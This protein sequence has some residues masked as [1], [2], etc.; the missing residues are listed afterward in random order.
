MAA[1][2]QHFCGDTLNIFGREDQSFQ[3]SIAYDYYS[4][5][6]AQKKVISTSGIAGADCVPEFFYFKELVTCCAENYILNQW[7][8]QLGNHS[9]VSLSPQVFRKM[10]TLPDPMPTFKGENCRQFLKKH[11]NELDLLP[12]FLQNPVAAPQDMAI[13]QVSAF[14]NPFRTNC[15]DFHEDNGTRKCSQHLSDDSVYF[16]FYGQ[17]TSHLPL[18]QVDFH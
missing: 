3:W 7:I 10:L 11:G 13:L 8:I 12:K 14:K 15:M 1:A 6:S 18:G 2:R 17:G 16:I 4:S 5:P 9:Q